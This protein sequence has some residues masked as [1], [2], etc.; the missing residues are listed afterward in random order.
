MSVANASAELIQ[1]IESRW[2]ITVEVEDLS[3]EDIFLEVTRA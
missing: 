2:A 1:D 3:L